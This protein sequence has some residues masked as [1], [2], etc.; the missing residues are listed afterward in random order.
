MWSD[1]GSIDYPGQESF[2]SWSKHK[3]RPFCAPSACD[4]SRHAPPLTGRLAPPQGLSHDD[5]VAAFCRIYAEAHTPAR[6][7]S[8][9]YK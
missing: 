4:R 7:K 5:A 9:F 2:D 8:N 3:V 1:D 6:A